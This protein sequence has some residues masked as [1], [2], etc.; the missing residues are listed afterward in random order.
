MVLSL[1]I[2]TI[3]V[4]NYISIIILFAFFKFLFFSIYLWDQVIQEKFVLQWQL[5]AVQPN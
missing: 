3:P 5:Y 2:F 4:L 1:I